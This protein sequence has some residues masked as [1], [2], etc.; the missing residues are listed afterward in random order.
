MLKEIRDLLRDKLWVPSLVEIADE[1]VLLADAAY[2]AGDVVSEN[3][4]I[5]AGAKPFVFRN[6][7]RKE[8][9]SGIIHD[10]LILAQTT[11]VASVFSLFLHKAT[12]T[13]ELGDGVP[14]TAFLLADRHIA[15]VRIDFTACDDVGAGMSETTATPSTYGKLPKAFT[16]QTGSR[17]LHGVL[18]IHNAVDLLDDTVLR[19]VL[20]VEQL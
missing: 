10:A 12:P 5:A 11:A 1:K 9:G 19:I 4:T 17:D 18:A 15:V 8:G 13:C 20:M 7:V 16:C 2:V 6:V 14:N 3:V